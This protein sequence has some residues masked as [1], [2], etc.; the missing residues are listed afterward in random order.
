MSGA[1]S[2]LVWAGWV[3]SVTNYRSV[4][5]ITDANHQ[6]VLSKKSC[7]LLAPRVNASLSFCRHDS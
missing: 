5:L 2:G 1:P 3:F 7:M 4:F 6:R